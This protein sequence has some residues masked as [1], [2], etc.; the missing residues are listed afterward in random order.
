MK[1]RTSNEIFMAI[2]VLVVLILVGAWF[3]RNKAANPAQVPSPTY[4][5]IT[6]TQA[7]TAEKPTGLSVTILPSNFTPA[8]VSCVVISRIPTPS[9][10]ETS[11][12]PAPTDT[13]W[14]EG[15]ATASVTF[16]EY[17]DFQ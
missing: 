9:A 8:A 6:D 3:L 1:K 16:L 15:P 13:D 14:T 2:L 5:K 12:F 10:T 4:A 11:L 17:S 7:T